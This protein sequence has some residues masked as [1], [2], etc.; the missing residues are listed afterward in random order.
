MV[1]AGTLDN[2]IQAPCRYSYITADYNAQTESQQYVHL[3]SLLHEGLDIF[4]CRRLVRDDNYVPEANWDALYS[5]S[6]KKVKL[7]FVF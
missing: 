1:A 2:L 3:S 4:H 7:L 6:H 5:L